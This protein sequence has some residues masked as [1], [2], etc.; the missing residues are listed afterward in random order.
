MT[1]L[2]SQL[3]AFQPQN[4]YSSGGAMCSVYVACGAVDVCGIVSQMDG[5]LFFFLCECTCVL[6]V[7]DSTYG[8]CGVLFVYAASIVLF[9]VAHASC[10]GRNV[11][12]QERP[13]HFPLQGHLPG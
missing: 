1:F 8:A 7:F 9:S 6:Q 2:Y 3:L 12:G 4:S 11:V 5:F 13:G 10:Y